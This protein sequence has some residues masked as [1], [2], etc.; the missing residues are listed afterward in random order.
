MED[1]NSMDIEDDENREVTGKHL[2]TRYSI[3][4]NHETLLEEIGLKDGRIN[5]EEY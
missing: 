5:E 2:D 3:P 1:V 4:Y